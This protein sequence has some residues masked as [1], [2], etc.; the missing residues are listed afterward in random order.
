MTLRRLILVEDE[1]KCLNGVGSREN[2]RREM[3]SHFLGSLLQKETKNG[4]VLEV[5]RYVVKRELFFKEI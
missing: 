3:V 1:S 4:I 2:G 5:D